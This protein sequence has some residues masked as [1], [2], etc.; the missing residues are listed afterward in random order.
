MY[1]LY[2]TNSEVLT[3]NSTTNTQNFSSRN[4]IV[5]HYPHVD[6]TV[7]IFP[8]VYVCPGDL[9]LEDKAEQMVAAQI[10]ERLKDK[11]SSTENSTRHVPCLNV[12][13]D[14]TE[15]TCALRM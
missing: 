15:H 6:V 8:I 9:P 1:L 2:R 12:R 4:L 11:R 3:F 14:H 5:S 13:M 7:F 10:S